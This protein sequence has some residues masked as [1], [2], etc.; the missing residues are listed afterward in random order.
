MADARV[1]ISAVSSGCGKT[2]I[3]CGILQCL[4]NR[5]L[6]V[7]SFKCG[8]DYID[9]MF[10]SKVIGTESNNIDSFFNDENTLKY[11]MDN[12]MK[13]CDISVIEGVMGYYD[14]VSL[15]NTKASSYEIACI[16]DTP[17]ILVLNCR[18]ISVS[19]IPI[20]KGFLEFKKD[21]KIKGVILNN[22]SKII[23]TDLKEYIEKE[24]NVKVLGYV[25]PLKECSIES[26]HLGL[27]TPSEIDDLKEKLNKL[28]E[29]LEKTIDID[30]II[31]L[32]NKAPALEYEEVKVPLLSERIKIGVAYDEAFCFYYKDNLN[33]LERMNAE[34]IFFSPLKDKVLPEGISGL[35]LGGGYP[36]LYAKELS[37][38]KSMLESIKK[39]ID[40][41]MPVLAE[42]GGF[43][44]LHEKIQGEDGKF[45]NMSGVI[46]GESFKTDSLRRFGYIKISSLEDNYLFKRGENILGHE[47]HYWDS[48]NCGEKFIACKTLRKK[49]WKCMHV[50]NNLVAGYP[51]MNYYS[52][53]N[54]PYRFLKMCEQYRREC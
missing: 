45:Y 33:I 26:R 2:T 54:I 47:F 19:I 39:N 9:P 37:K 16:T 28:G 41:N 31:N 24:I 12:S 43:M 40:D 6:K 32:A 15:K 38:N 49:D 34:L 25:P 1:M 11:L 36:E 50:I 51:H 23:Y 21:S 3:T 10:H 53:I 17:V 29:T 5:K 30:E 14:G 44:Y 46:K 35:I 22:M 4:I 42:C 48:T 20:I 18:G 52:N 13:S 8:P 27:V 7:S